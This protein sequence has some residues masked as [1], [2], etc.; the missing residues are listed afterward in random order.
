MELKIFEG[1]SI[2]EALDKCFAYGYKP[3]NLVLV[4]LLKKSRKIPEQWYD[5]STIWFKDTGEIRDATKKELM[6]IEEIYK[7]DGRLLILGDGD[8]YG[9]CGGSRIGDGGR[10]VGVRNDE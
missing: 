10:F 2:K 8:G 9:L 5:T 1:N 6:N 4:T 3:A 7:K